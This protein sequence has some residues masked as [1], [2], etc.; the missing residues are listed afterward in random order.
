MDENLQVLLHDEL[1]GLFG[2]PAAP[3]AGAAARRAPPPLPPPRPA[4]PRAPAS[5]PEAGDDAPSPHSEI[6][7]LLAQRLHDPHVLQALARLL[8][9]R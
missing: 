8:G 3:G 4:P 5:A 7:A 1:E 9:V 2:A 6:A